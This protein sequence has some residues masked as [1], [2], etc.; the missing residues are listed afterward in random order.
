MTMHVETAPRS[1]HASIRASAPKVRQPELDL[2]SALPRYWLAGNAFAT[3]VANGVNLLFPA[4]E[5]F[6][7]RSVRHF[8]PR[9]SDPELVARVQGFFGQEGAHARQ[10]ERAFRQLVDRGLDVERFARL[11]DAVAY[12]FI[13]RLASPE[14]RLATTAACEHFTAIMA[15]DALEARFLD[16]APESMRSLLF[17]HAAEEIEHRSVAFDVLSA[18]AP[19]YSLRMAGLAMATLCLGGFWTLATL[20]LLAQDDELDWARLVEDRRR[21]KV[22]ERSVPRD[23]DVFLRGIREYLRRDFHPSQMDVDHLADAYLA[24]VGLAPLSRV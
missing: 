3:H 20:M 18:V 16:L 14:L 2:D 9:L 22:F 21:L 15:S 24:S 8:V 12:R 17:W 13:E 6:F 7:V 10:H 11:Y 5:R 1:V 23:R 4:G 19:S